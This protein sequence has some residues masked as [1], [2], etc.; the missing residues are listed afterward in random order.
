MPAHDRIDAVVKAYPVS[1]DAQRHRQVLGRF[2]TEIRETL[3]CS[4]VRP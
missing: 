2:F 4:R 1:A 3:K